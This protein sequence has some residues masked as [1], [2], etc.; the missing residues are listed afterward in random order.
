MSEHPRSYLH[1]DSKE[2]LERMVN[3]PSDEELA[4]ELDKEP[5]D[6]LDATPAGAIAAN[7]RLKASIDQSSG[8][9]GDDDP[10]SWET[11]AIDK[12][13]GHD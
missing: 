4:A 2:A 9:G 10:L 3:P 12:V 7:E 5:G 11:K 13:V 1:E 8:M 6:K